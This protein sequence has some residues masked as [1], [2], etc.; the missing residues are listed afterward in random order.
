MRACPLVA[1]LRF[2]PA[3]WPFYGL[4]KF[5][6]LPA[7]V[8]HE[9]LMIIH[10]DDS[11]LIPAIAEEP[12]RVEVQCQPRRLFSS[13]IAKIPRFPGSPPNERV[14]THAHRINGSPLR[15]AFL[16][17][18]CGEPSTCDRRQL[19]R[20]LIG[21]PDLYSKCA[22]DVRFGQELHQQAWQDAAAR[23]QPSPSTQATFPERAIYTI[24][25]QAP[26]SP[27][28]LPFPT[29]AQPTCLTRHRRP[30]GQGRTHRHS[31]GRCREGRKFTL[32]PLRRKKAGGRMDGERRQYSF[33]DLHN[34]IWQITPAAWVVA[35]SSAPELRS[36]DLEDV[37]VLAEDAGRATIVVK[38]KTTTRGEVTI[39]ATVSANGD[40]ALSQPEMSEVFGSIFDDQA[41]KWLASVIVRAVGKG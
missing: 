18:M 29:R 33:D 10:P 2:G 1:W 24:Q 20:S 13:T 32:F 9:K 15:C 12:A 17:R 28:Q 23:D 41:D 35:K 38:I 22:A 7:T 21:N 4:K 30:H 3:G 14:P 6:E 25:T 11:R 31:L 39:R 19:V 40:L 34:R 5:G 37:Q 8:I 27:A 26:A 16:R 36:A